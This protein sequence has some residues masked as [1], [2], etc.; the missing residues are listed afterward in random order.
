MIKNKRPSSCLSIMEF[1]GEPCNAIRQVFTKQAPEVTQPIFCSQLKCSRKRKEYQ[2]GRVYYPAK[3][4]AD[5]FD[6]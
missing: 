3:N 1:L 2:I 6:W 4:I 5:G